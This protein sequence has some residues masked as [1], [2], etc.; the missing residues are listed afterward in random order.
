MCQVDAAIRQCEGFDKF[1]A[2]PLMPESI[3]AEKLKEKEKTQQQKL[4]TQI[5]GLKLGNLY[6]SA[7]G[8][9]CLF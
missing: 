2:K 3:S 1:K 7:K 5:I 9:F 4:L 8:I 6:D